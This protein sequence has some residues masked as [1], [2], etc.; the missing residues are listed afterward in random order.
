MVL[1][2]LSELDDAA[3]EEGIENGVDQ[4]GVSTVSCATYFCN[5]L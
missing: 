3:A 4:N 5:V 2:A 1:Q